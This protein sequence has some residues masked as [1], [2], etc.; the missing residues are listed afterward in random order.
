MILNIANILGTPGASPATGATAA[1]VSDRVI[2]G[3]EDIDHD[4]VEFSPEGLALSRATGRSSL[5]LARQQSIRAEINAGTYLT[6]E[7][8]QGT[9][10]RLLDVLT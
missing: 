2:S 10:E 7:R 6:P 1:N 4:S 9:V 3:R 8:L 5:R